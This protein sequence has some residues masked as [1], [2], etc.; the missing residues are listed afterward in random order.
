[1]MFNR[2]QVARFLADAALLRQLLIETDTTLTYKKFGE[3][4]G[5]SR[6]SDWSQ[7][8]NEN[9]SMICQVLYELEHFNGDPAHWR[10]ITWET[11]TPWEWSGRDFAWARRISPA[12]RN[13]IT[14]R[15]VPHG[16]RDPGEQPAPQS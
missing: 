3:M 7:D 6:A 11:G 5:L 2:V 16:M 14:G 15:F 4:I 9:L 10:M 12:M 13:L 8:D 1:M